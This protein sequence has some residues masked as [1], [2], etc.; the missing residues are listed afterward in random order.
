MASSGASSDL[1]DRISILREGVIFSVM[2]RLLTRL[3]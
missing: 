3:C 2:T 1:S